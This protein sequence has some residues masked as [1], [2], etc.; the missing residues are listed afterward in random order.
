MPFIYGQN[1]GAV[2]LSLQGRIGGTN[3][4]TS[5]WTSDSSMSMKTPPGVDLGADLNVYMPGMEVT[6]STT[7]SDAFSYDSPNI[8]GIIPPMAVGGS[9]ITISGKNMGIYDTS[10][11]ASVGGTACMAVEWQSTESILCKTVDGV[12]GE[13]DVV[14]TT[15]A[16]TSTFVLAVAFTFSGPVVTA[17]ILPN[18]PQGGGTTITIAGSSFGGWDV[19]PLAKAGDTTCA[20]TIW[21]SSSSLQALLPAGLGSAAITVEESSTGTV[22]SGSK[23][24]IFHFDGP[25]P[26]SVA[27]ANVPGTG[28]TTLTVLGSNFGSYTDTTKALTAKIGDTD[29]TTTIWT[30]D[31]SASCIAAV[32]VGAK[33]PLTVDLGG[34]G[35]AMDMA[36]TYDGFYVDSLSASNAPAAGGASITITGHLLGTDISPPTVKFGAA[37]AK[38]AW[39]SATSISV[40]IPPYFKEYGGT[41]ISVTAGRSQLLR[42]IFSYDAVEITSVKPTRGELVGGNIVTVTGKNFGGT[43]SSFYVTIGDTNCSKVTWVSD[44]RCLCVA[45]SSSTYSLV[46]VAYIHRGVSHVSMQDLDNYPDYYFNVSDAYQYKIF[47]GPKVIGKPVE[48]TLSATEGATME[49][50]GGTKLEIASGA[51]PEGTIAAL[52]EMTPFEGAEPQGSDEFASALL[53]IGFADADGNPVVPTK[54]IPLTIPVNLNTRRRVGLEP[55]SIAAASGPPAHGD[56]LTESRPPSRRLLQAGGVSIRAAWLDKCTG[57]WKA[58]CSTTYDAEL[59]VVAGDIPTTVFAENCFNPKSGC[60]AAIV[61]AQQCEGEGGTFSA[62]S[63]AK[64]PCPAAE[65]ANDDRTVAIIVGSVLGVVT[66]CLCAAMLIWRMRTLQEDEDESYYSDKSYSDDDEEI[67]SQYMSQASAGSFQGSPRMYPGSYL[68]GS[69]PAAGAMVPPGYGMQPMMGYGVPQTPYGQYGA[70]AGPME[71]GYAD[72]G[73]GAMPMGMGLPPPM[74]AQGMG[75]GAMAGGTPQGY[76]PQGFQGFQG[77]PGYQQ[78]GEREL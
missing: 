2:D 40:D 21:I 78:S 48:V 49:L 5:H 53:S 71:P 70:S 3:A 24:G 75:S 58:I 42:K 35:N 43:S 50:A 74:F 56:L 52:A 8:V 19:S 64:D 10:M 20:T 73:L 29:C 38:V 30:S 22:F 67:G 65:A 60:T 17:A 34:S 25:R 51:F 62:M 7:L 47:N 26:T 57:F 6:H 31:S 66:L 63:F 54:D 15:A 46:S 61:E 33:L 69:Y 41:D 59:N 76:Y 27:R 72:M 28:G 37:D 55:P 32:G 39:T 16:G 44:V 13:N 45:P 11:S 14:L 1:F 23:A 9:T 68:P 12:G 36:I 77:S 4:I 18:G